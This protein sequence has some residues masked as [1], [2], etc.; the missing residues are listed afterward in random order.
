MQGRVAE[1]IHWLTEETSHWQQNNALAIHNHWHLALM[2]LSNRDE[3]AALA[4]YDRAIAP[5]PAAM[6]LDLVDASGLLWRLGLRGVD[7]AGRWEALAARWQAQAAWGWSVFNDTHALLAFVGAG[8]ASRIAQGRAAIEAV[9]HDAPL[10]WWNEAGALCEAVTAFGRGDYARC[11]Q[12]LLPLLPIAHG[13]G[14][15]QAQRSLIFLTAMEAARRAGDSALHE[16]LASEVAM[17]KP[18][19]TAADVDRRARVLESA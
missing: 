19:W 3:A 2:H 16:A 12:L 9:A 14:G 7:V 8:K 11:A 18:A 17:R 4:L 13:F 5:G 15:S 10:P 1:G 6:A